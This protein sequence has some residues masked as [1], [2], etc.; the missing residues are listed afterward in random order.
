MEERGTP[1]P[2]QI[3]LEKAQKF[4]DV[5]DPNRKEWFFLANQIATGFAPQSICRLWNEM[6]LSGV[7]YGLGR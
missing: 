3:N 5:I 7:R 6:S 1:I 2:L 4:L